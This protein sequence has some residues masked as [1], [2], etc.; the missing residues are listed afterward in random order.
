MLAV[1]GLLQGALQGPQQ[2]FGQEAAI[3]RMR[4]LMSFAGQAA[5]GTAAAEE[6]AGHWQ[7]WQDSAALAF[8]YIYQVALSIRCSC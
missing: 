7:L 3:T 1:G 6:A 4:S 8:T 2:V 5:G